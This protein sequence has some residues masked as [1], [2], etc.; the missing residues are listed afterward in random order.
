LEEVPVPIILSIFSGV[1]LHL[2][3]AGVLTGF[4]IVVLLIV[5][6]AFISGAEVSYFSLKASELDDLAKEKESSVI[7]KLLKKPNQLLATILIANNFIN[8][9]II[10]L[11]AYL[12]SL[13]ISFPEDSPLE[14]IFQVFIITLLLVLFGEITPKVYANQNAKQFSL[15]MAKPLIFLTKVFYPLSYLLVSTTNFID[16]RLAQKQTEVS[17]E[18]ITKAL[19]ITEH[20]SK[21]D[22]RKILRSI[23]EFGNTD[24]KEV[25][26][27]RVDV[28][29]IEHKTKFKEVL[30]LIISSGFSR[31]PV[32]KEQFDTIL[33]ILY[34]KD[35][36]PFLDE[37][38][39]FDWLK[40]CRVPYYVP[41][42]KMINDLLKEFQVK[43]NHIAIVVD[44][45][46]GTSGIVT[47]EDLLEE[48]VGEIND[49]FDA[50]EN[51]YSK[52]DDHNF[53]FEGKISLIDFLK[54]VKGENNYFDEIKGE[55][56][57]LA[58]LVLE[59]EGRILKIGDICKIPPY[60]MLVESA[61][62]RQI[63]RL[64]VSINEN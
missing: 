23:V 52:L 64:K 45:Y 33:G 22:E 18:E 6:S 3:N 59:V 41:E 55:S 40:L 39:E 37:N 7:L 36:I 11:S 8:V 49:E 34:I 21:K 25:M 5:C 46:G 50:D 44:E 38:D 2:F 15:N 4:C 26:K 51:I 20:E 61:D 35:L 17:I 57:S 58:G 24:V 47:L 13:T 53:I 14:F 29:A 42:T 31:I 16:K 27:S 1:E 9:A 63:K 19:D 32:Y 43:K 10:V 30:Q 62:S 56:D 28:L 60:T 54:I 12:T 48:I